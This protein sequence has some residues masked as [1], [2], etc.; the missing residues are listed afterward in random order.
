MRVHSVRSVLQPAEPIL[1]L[2]PQDH[3]LLI[4]TRIDPLHI[5]KIDRGK[6]VALRFTALDQR[7]TPKLEGVVSLIS[8]GSFVDD[9]DGAS[10]YRAEIFLEPEEMVKLVGNSAL[11]PR[12]P[13]E[14][15]I[16]TADR[17]PLSC[18]L[19]PIVYYFNLAFRES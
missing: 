5:D 2:I 4:V 8:T 16:R 3:L 9:G 15:F 17:S 12:M 7:T 13:V 11:I 1:F 6:R 10:Y 19:K 18:L 14:I